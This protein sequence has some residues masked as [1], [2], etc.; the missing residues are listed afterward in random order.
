MKMSETNTNFATIAVSDIPKTKFIQKHNRKMT[1]SANYLYPCYVKD[2]VPGDNFDLSMASLTR[3]TTLKV[4]VM[5]ELQQKTYFF[6]V[7]Y[8]LV[9]DNFVRMM[10]QQDNPTDSIDYTEPQVEAPEGGFGPESLFDYLNVNPYASG[11]SVSSL[12]PRA[13]NL[14]YNEWF[15]AEQLVDSVKINKGD[16]GD[17]YTDFVLQKKSKIHDYFTSCLPTTQRGEA[18]TIPL[19]TTSPVIGNG[20]ALG[21]SDGTTNL[22]SMWNNYGNEN[23]AGLVSKLGSTEFGYPYNVGT[24]GAADTNIAGNNKA[25]G[26]SSNPDYS[27]LIADLSNATAATINAFRYAFQ[28]QKLL[29]RDNRAGCMRYTEIIQAHFNTIN[30]DL[31]MYRPQYLGCCVQNINFVPVSQ[32]SAT[33]A[34]GTPQG[35]LSAYGVGTGA[36]K[37]FKGSFG[38]WGVILGL[39]CISSIPSYQQG[40]PRHFNRHGRYDYYYPEFAHLGEQEVLKKEIYSDGTENDNDVFGYQERY[41]ELRYEQNEICGKM[42]SD[43]TNSLDIWHL[44]QDLTSSVALN[45][46]FI[47]EN[48][49]ISRVVAVTNEPEF[50]TVMNFY[51]EATRPLPMYGTPGFVD[52]F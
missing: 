16:N 8:R 26:V 19:G 29:E 9:W 36:D 1:M 7:P 39:T 25:V 21:L 46:D 52:H 4:P 28:L 33:G 24:D 35:N 43:N 49:P 47:E 34:T 48:I 51:N 17:L 27:G 2:V 11:I 6:F 31:Q 3:M 30:P 22:W 40:V 12:I 13:Y 23:K 14:I 44:S 5:D 41:A 10:G 38:E 50:I 18:V 42:R 45:Q 15:R 20:K 32:N 37:A